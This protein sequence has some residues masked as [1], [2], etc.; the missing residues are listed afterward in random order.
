MQTPVVRLDSPGAALPEAAGPTLEVPPIEVPG[1]LCRD[2]ARSSRL[3]WL[4]VDGNGGFA[5]GTVAG[6]N[7]RR[8]HGLLVAALHPPVD[9][10]VLLS[11]LEEEVELPGG[12]RFQLGCAQYPGAVAPEGFRHLQGFALDPFPTWRFGLGALGIE[13][14]LLMLHGQATTIVEYRASLPCTLRLRPLIAGR[15]FHAL[16]HRNPQLDGR[17]AIDGA[18]GRLRIAPYAGLPPLTLHHGGSASAEG[19]AWYERAEYLEELDRGLDFREDLYCLGTITLELAPGRPGWLLA[20][21]AADDGGWDPARLGAA[22]EGERARR[23]ERLAWRD[24]LTRRLAVAADAYRARR[25]DGAATVMAGFPWFA[26]WGRDTMIALPGLLIARGLLGEAEQVLTGFLEH[27]DAGLL[28]NRFVDGGE[29]PE[30]NT[31]DAT[32][33]LFQAVRAL[34]AAGGDRAWAL[35]VF[36]PRALTIYR[37]HLRGTHHGIVVDPEDGLLC[38]GGPGSQLT[39]MDAKVGD[40]VM[41]PRHGKPVEVNAL[42]LAALQLLEELLRE[43]GQPEVAGEVAEQRSRAAASFVRAFWNPARGCLHDVVPARLPDGSQPPPDARVRPNQVFAVSLPGS[44]LSI[45]QQRSVL[46]VVRDQLLTPVGLRTLAPDEPGYRG[47]YHGDALSRDA[48]YHQGTVWPW[49]LGP[50]VSAWLRAHGRTPENLAWGRALLAPLA[51]HLEEEACLGQV[52]EVFDGDAPHRPGGAV[53]QAWSVAELLR[54]VLT[55]LDGE[56]AP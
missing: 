47:R 35:R 4:E 27:L 23:R 19:A 12:A 18:A 46:Q 38:A 53:A 1:G 22:I 11:R 49:L 29:P 48:A 31:A 24:P 40:Q 34:L 44:P 37:F 43:A 55:E 52:S 26:D 54:L 14:R 2:F 51:R 56:P 10:V 25:H 9:R 5:M 15:D 30:Y 28:P 3:E 42:W 21:T 8:Y 6:V 17:L 45:E 41:T 13:R 36:L 39:W 7:T 32:L 33:W 50:F 20:T 16:T